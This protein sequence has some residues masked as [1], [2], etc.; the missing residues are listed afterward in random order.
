MEFQ[1]G[2]KV[3]LKVSRLERGLH[4]IEEPLEILD[5]E[6]KRL[7]RSR[8]PLV[9]VRWNSK[10]GHE[11]TWEREDQF[12][13]KYP[14]LS[15]RNHTVVKCCIYHAPYSYFFPL[16]DPNLGVLERPTQPRIVYLPILNINYFHHFLDILENYNPVD[17]EPMWAADRVVTL[18]P[19]SAINIPET[20]NA[21]TIKAFSQHENETL[22]DA[23]LRVKEMLRNFH[24]RNL[25]KG[26]IIKIFY[27]GLNEITQEVLNSTAGGIFLY[28]T[29]N[30]AYQLL[31]YKVLLK[32]D[33]AKNQK[34]KSS[35]KKTVAFANKG[36][37]K[38]DID[39]IM[40]Q[41]DAMTMKM[42]ALYKEMQS[43]SN[44]SIPEYDKDDKP[45]SPEAKAK[46]M[47]TFYAYVFTMITATVTQI[48]I[49]GVQAKEMII[50]ETS[51]DPIPKINPTF[52]DD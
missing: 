9:K 47:Q 7:K 33:W 8:I 42:D 6:V 30:Q 16:A 36:S 15:S 14:H 39:K 19:G 41:M 12:K 45:V 1:V 38:Y 49:I 20:I 46:F 5:R 17:D 24:G 22:T 2:D 13:K 50:I 28:K 52:K 34:P 37:S 40:A 4:F 26:N 3:M 18:T 11:F 35:F 43:N 23:W 29:P 51:I 31:E 48:A 25:S 21:F 10:R 44:H 32:L 27:H